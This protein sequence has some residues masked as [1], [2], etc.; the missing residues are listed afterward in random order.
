[1]ETQRTCPPPPRPAPTIKNNIAKKYRKSPPLDSCF[2]F[3]DV[4]CSLQSSQCIPVKQ[5]MFHEEEIGPLLE[6]FFKPTSISDPSP[7]P[8]P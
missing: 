4:S 1:M 2:G 6:I 3:H 8:K 7:N 5:E